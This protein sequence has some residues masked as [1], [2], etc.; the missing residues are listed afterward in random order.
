[1]Q[2]LKGKIESERLDWILKSIWVVGSNGVYYFRNQKP[3]G[4]L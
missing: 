4:D 3:H 1:M 2:R